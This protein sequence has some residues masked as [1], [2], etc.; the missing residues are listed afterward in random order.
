MCIVIHEF[1]SFSV[2]L[3]KKTNYNQTFSWWAWS[4]SR[5]NELDDQMSITSIFAWGTFVRG[6]GYLFLGSG[7]VLSWAVLGS[8]FFTLFPLDHSLFINI[9]FLYNEDNAIYVIICSNSPCLLRLCLNKY[10]PNITE[11]PSQQFIGFF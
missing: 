6:I 5:E 2:K 4:Q 11:L 8:F 10:N 7:H 1:S 9:F 3:H